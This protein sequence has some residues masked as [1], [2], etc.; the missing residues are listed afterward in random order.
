MVALPALIVGQASRQFSREG[1]FLNGTSFTVTSE[2]LDLS[3][4]SLVAFSFRTCTP[5][6]LLRQT[7]DSLDQ[8][9]IQIDRTGRLFLTLTVLDKRVDL[10]AGTSLLDG[11]WHTVRVNVGPNMDQ[12]TLSVTLD[13]EGTVDSTQRSASDLDGI[14]RQLNLTATTPEL[15]IGAGM[16]ACI[17][18]GP[19]VRFT[20]A[21]IAIN[22]QAV[23]WDRC[24]L[25]YTC[26]GKLGSP[27]L[28]ELSRSPRAFSE[29]G[30]NCWLLLEVASDS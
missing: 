26:T 27:F 7:G 15:R 22:S 21:G 16:I 20:K 13:A 2:V 8:L 25:P 19:G 28:N 12:L 14:L 29:S 10:V 30:S 9:R 6:E 18:E 1:F 3:G 17:R 11:Q 23:R 4:G 24:L 5:G